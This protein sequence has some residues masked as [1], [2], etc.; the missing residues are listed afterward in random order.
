MVVQTGGSCKWTSDSQRFLLQHFDAIY[1][2]PFQIY[3]YAPFCP[4]SSWLQKC[5]GQV[6]K[7]VK[8]V[9]AK[10][11][12][13]SRTIALND[14]AYA[15]SYKNNTV[16]VGLSHRDIIMLDAITGSQTAVLSGHIGPV[17]SL[18]FSLD[19]RLLGSGS[20]TV[21]LWD[22]QTG[23]IIKTFSGHAD[24]C[25]RS[26]SISADCTRIASGSNMW[27]AYLWDIQ[28]GECHYFIEHQDQVTY[29]GFSPTNPQ[30]LITISGSKVQKWDTGGH[31][32]G[33]IYNGSH[34][35][36]S[37]DNIHFALCNE[38]VV[39]VQA[40]DSGAILTEF[41]FSEN[42][43]AEH[44]CFSPDGRLIAAVSG[45][46]AYVWS[47]SNSSF[48][49]VGTF[50]GHTDTITSL[51]FSSPSTLISASEDRSVKFW[52]ID[53]TS[54]DQVI[55]E[56]KSTPPTSA[57]IEFVSLQAKE[58]IAISGDSAGVIKTWDLTTGLCKASFQTT[59]TWKFYGDAQLIDD[60]LL[61]IWGYNDK[62]HIWDTVRGEFPQVL[63]TV[64]PYGI[65][66]SGDRSKV[67]TVDW[68]DGASRIQAWSVG[69]WELVCEVKI[70][71]EKVKEEWKWFLDPF[72]ADGSKV[73][74]R[75]KDLSVKGWDF[76]ISGSLSGPLRPTSSLVYE[77]N[78]EQY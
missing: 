5:S 69:T 22:V 32:T 14:Y 78:Y 12:T 17:K 40:S 3:N 72:C 25:F 38:N 37:P 66:I 30:H 18:V 24:D 77:T 54:I 67:F 75:C 65:R 73:W 48:P 63:D 39:T 7:V 57:S 62:C 74:V 41:Q 15:L 76:G 8:G 36:L 10:W 52:Q 64:D 45:E 29:V 9:E 35:A 27:E 11:G 33:P 26:V 13:C 70:E 1:A 43:Y 68:K 60:R 51:T 20:L 2:A 61:F 34:I 56:L 44:C 42:S 28:T 71:V 31:Q 4:S 16:A 23:G 59:A 6:V 55:T 49:L 46:I 50:S 21:K 47:I 58:G 19:G 53:A